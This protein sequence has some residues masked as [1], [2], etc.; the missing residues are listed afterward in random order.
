[1]AAPFPRHGV[2]NCTKAKKWHWTQASKHTQIHF[3]LLMSMYVL[4]EIPALIQHMMFHSLCPEWHCVRVCHPKS[5]TEPRTP[6][7]LHICGIFV[8][9]CCC[10]Y[11]LCIL[12]QDILYFRQD[13]QGWPL[14][15]WSS[16]FDLQVLGLQACTAILV[17]LV[18]V[19]KPRGLWILGKRPA[20]IATSPAPYVFVL[21]KIISAV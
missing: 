1:M 7:P 13:G 10:G 21:K 18:L 17:C 19:M 5:R 15:F 2:L 14:D 3:I 20:N 11:M 16:C 9:L 4:F 6:V 8:S 12:R